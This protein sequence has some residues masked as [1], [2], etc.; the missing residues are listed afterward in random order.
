MIE[1]AVKRNFQ[2]SFPKPEMKKSKHLTQLLSI[3]Y[4]KRKKLMFC[5]RFLKMK[6]I[7]R[8]LLMQDTSPEMKAKYREMLM[9]KTPEERF[10]MGISMFETARELAL[11][12]LPKTA[13][14]QEKREFL[15][16]RFYP[17]EYA[18]LKKRGV[19]IL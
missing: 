19:E 6:K 18:D 1:I 9:A 17:Q 14:E 8:S 16:K 10:L 7:S 12:S 2:T 11:A 4:S 13:T 5:F 3:F 15:L